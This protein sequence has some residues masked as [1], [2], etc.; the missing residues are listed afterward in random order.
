MADGYEQL[1]RRVVDAAAVV[2]AEARRTPV[3]VG[4]GWEIPVP[5]P[6]PGLDAGDDAFPEISEGGRTVRIE[7]LPRR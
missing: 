3:A 1:Y 5:P 2:G 4:P 6:M 7:P